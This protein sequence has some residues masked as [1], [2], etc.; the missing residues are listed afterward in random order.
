MNIRKKI[1][2]VI[3]ASLFAVPAAHASIDL[4]AIGSLSGTFSD[5]SSQTSGPLENGV[6]G[7]V[8]GGLVRASAG[9]AAIPLSQPRTADP[10]PPPT[11]P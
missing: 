7:N 1:I 10:M 3:C 6:V 5:L 4:I 2:P 9:Q 8:L 11:I